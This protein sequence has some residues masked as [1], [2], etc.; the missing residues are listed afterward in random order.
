MEDKDRKRIGISFR[1]AATLNEKAKALRK[2]EVTHIPE[3]KTRFSFRPGSEAKIWSSEYE[4]AIR[5]KEQL[6]REF[7]GKALEEAIPGRVAS[8][9]YGECYQIAGWHPERLKKSNMKSAGNPFFQS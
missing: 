7:E 3:K 1:V 9:E 8:N 6:V 2:Y 4:E 5:L